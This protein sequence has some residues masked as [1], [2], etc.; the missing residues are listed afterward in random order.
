MC[1]SG[2]P[3][4]SRPTSTTGE[5]PVSNSTAGC[6]GQTATN[7]TV[8]APSATPT[9]RAGCFLSLR[10]VTASR[11]QPNGL[12]ARSQVFELLAWCGHH[13]SAFGTV[14]P[15]CGPRS[16]ESSILAGQVAHRARTTTCTGTG[17]RTH[18]KPGHSPKLWILIHRSQAIEPDAEAGQ[19]QASP[20]ALPAFDVLSGGS[21]A[22][23][24]SPSRPVSSAH[25]SRVTGPKQMRLELRGGLGGLSFL[26]P[27]AWHQSGGASSGMP[28]VMRSARIAQTGPTIPSRRAR[29]R[30]CGSARH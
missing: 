5:R 26:D 6:P 7:G 3:A 27:Q 2:T 9:P 29:H 16:Q 11:W 10:H 8:T 30:C 17:T 15:E 28:C 23:S 4:T 20:G 24:R 22:A 13:A 19:P 18:P 1:R 12:R 21:T 14:R 25:G